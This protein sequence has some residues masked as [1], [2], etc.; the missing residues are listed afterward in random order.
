MKTRIRSGEAV[1]VLVD[2]GVAALLVLG[3]AYAVYSSWN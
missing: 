2:V 1:Y 3:I